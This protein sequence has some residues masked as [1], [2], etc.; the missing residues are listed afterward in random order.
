[1]ADGV[2]FSPMTSSTGAFK[3]RTSPTLKVMRPAPPAVRH[4]TLQRVDRA[5]PAQMVSGGSAQ[6]G[7][8]TLNEVVIEEPTVS[9]FHCEISVTPDG[10]VVRDLGS[11][12]G[13]EV[14]GVRVKEA[15]LKN[16]SLLR[17]GN[18]TVRFQLELEAT[19]EPLAKGDTFGPLWGASPQMR[20]CFAQLE[21][22]AETSRPVLIEGETGTGK[23][24]AAE[25][26]HDSGSR[27]DE[28][29]LPVDCSSLAPADLEA[30]LVGR[31]SPRRLSAFEEARE[32]TLFLDEVAELPLE[33]QGR[34][35]TVLEKGELR[36]PGGLTVS[37]RARVIASTRADLRQLVNQ[38]RFRSE[39]YF[40]LAV[41]R[42]RMPPLRQH[43][44][45][46]PELVDSWLEDSGTTEEEAEPLRSQEFLSRLQ[47]AAWPGNVRELY[48]HLDHCRVMRAPLSP[49]ENAP[50]AAVRPSANHTWAEGKRLANEEFERGYV[51]ALL[52]RHKGKVSEA[53][54]AAQM[55]RVYLYRLIKRYGLKA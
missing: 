13:T 29:F 16:G 28:P 42:V 52:E 3:R 9:R 36:R 41:M 7:S 33:L 50:A 21:R 11:A 40:R 22:A 45:D 1:M 39:L 35:V 19:A 26:V 47:G 15:F 53:A 54:R 48:N 27:K 38:N 55:D 8:H 46:I 30:M 20:A 49:G 5:G 18:A 25:A 12:N 2:F 37:V 32:G 14:D 34:L 44:E 43:P 31:E 17:L 10:P 24:A 23:T 6:V 4:F 51:E